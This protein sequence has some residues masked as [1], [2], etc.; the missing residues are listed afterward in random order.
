MKT[1]QIDQPHPI[2]WPAAVEDAL[3]DL[4]AALRQVYGRKAPRVVLYGSYARGEADDTSDVDVLLLYPDRIVV[5]EE[6]QRLG[7]ILADLNLR[8]QVL[9]SILPVS[10]S[11]W[12]TAQNAF[13]N[14]I[15]REGVSLA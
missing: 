5:G 4:R 14:N 10:Q 3:R 13:W 12:K 6:I 9:I 15:R 1:I 2:H 8:Y 11:D 7:A